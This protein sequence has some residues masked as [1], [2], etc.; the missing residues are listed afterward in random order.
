MMRIFLKQ[1]QAINQPLGF[2]RV[3]LSAWSHKKALARNGPIHDKDG[4]TRRKREK[5]E[6][7]F[8]GCTEASLLAYS[9]TVGW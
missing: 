4:C 3:M 6:C 8:K 1:V 9:V 5:M 7:G 2:S